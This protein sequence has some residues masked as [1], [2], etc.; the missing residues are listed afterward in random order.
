LR[1]VPDGSGPTAD[2]QRGLVSRLETLLQ[3][4]SGIE[5]EAMDFVL[6]A[7]SGKFRLT[8]NATLAPGMKQ[9]EEIS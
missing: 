3:S 4:P 5:V 9:N 7:P 2:E 1:L 8:S 6:P